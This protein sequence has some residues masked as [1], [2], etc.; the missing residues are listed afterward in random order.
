MGSFMH[1]SILKRLEKI[2]QSLSIEEEENKLFDVIFMDVKK[3]GIFGHSHTVCRRGGADFKRYPCTD[4]EEIE[5]MRVKYEEWNHKYFGQGEELSFPDFLELFFYMS[6]N[7][8]DERKKAAVQKLREQE[9]A[10]NKQ[11]ASSTQS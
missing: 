7:V 8:P 10:Q 6:P 9:K 3:G 4:E 2:E 1:R 11:S 5:F